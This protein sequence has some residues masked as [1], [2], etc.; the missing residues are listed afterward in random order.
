MKRNILL[1]KERMS[2]IIKVIYKSKKNTKKV[3]EAIAKALNVEACSMEEVG[4]IE[5]TDILFLGCGIYGGNVPPEMNGFVDKIN[6]DTVKKVVLFTTSGMGKN[7][8]NHFVELLKSKNIKLETETFSGTG[9]F[10]FKNRKQPDENTLNEAIAFA[11]KMVK[12]EQS[13]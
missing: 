10:L 5:H 4:N 3:A 11:H 13:I 6:S 2:M 7:Q 8:T 12:K 1:F 9:K